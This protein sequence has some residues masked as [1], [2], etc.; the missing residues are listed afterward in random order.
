MSKRDQRAALII[1]L[2]CAFIALALFH[3]PAWIIQ[4]FR[5][6]A[7][8]ELGYALILRRIAPVATLLLLII[9]SVAV[10]YWP[11]RGWRAALSTLAILLVVVTAAAVRINYFEWMF[12]PN[13][14]PQSVAARDASVE[15]DDMVLVARVGGDARAFPVRIMAYHHLVNDTVGGLPI[16]PTY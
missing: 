10:L 12:H 2:V 7:Q 3:I 6:Q 4:P 1:A 13:L 9:A 14:S 11:P 16:L 8:D 5:P 15:S